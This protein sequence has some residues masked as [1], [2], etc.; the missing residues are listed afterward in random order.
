MKKI[1]N[2]KVFI[3]TIAFIGMTGVL[4]A[5]VLAFP[6]AE[7]FGANSLGG[8]GGQVIHVTT[9]NDSGPGSLREA[10]MTTGPRYVVF[11]VSGTIN[12]S[13]KIRLNASHSYLYLAG[14]TSPG[15]VQLKGTENYIMLNDGVHDVII[16]YM[17][18]RPG[19]PI[20]TAQT[21]NCLAIY[22]NTADPVT[23]IIIDHCDLMWGGDEMASNYGKTYRTT[24]QWNIIAETL[25]V[26]GIKGKGFLADNWETEA[27]Q[28]QI[29][30]SILK[31]LWVHNHDRSPKVSRSGTFDVRNNVVYNWNSNSGAKFG[32]TSLDH[33]A[34]GN[35]VNNHY[36]GGPHSTPNAFF[37]NGGSSLGSRD[38]GGTKV[39]VSGNWNDNCPTGC[40]AG[41]WTDFV[42]ITTDTGPITLASE[43]EFRTM[44]AFPVPNTTTLPTSGLKATILAGAG[45][46]LPSIDAAT[47]KV[48]DDVANSTGA[49]R[50]KDDIGGPWPD[51]ETGA[52]NPAQDTDQD[53]I[54][55]QWETD[56][57]MDANDPTD[58]PKISTNGYAYIEN[59]LNDLAGDIVPAWDN[60]GC[61][62]CNIQ[63]PFTTL[64]V[65]SQHIE[66]ED[67]DVGYPCDQNTSY[68]DDSPGNGGNSTARNDDVDLWE[69]AGIIRVGSNNPGEW[70][71]YGINLPGGMYNFTA[72]VATPN[73]GAKMGIQLGD[74][75]DGTNF[76]VVDT[77]DIP[78]TGSFTNFQNA[79]KNIVIGNGG[80]GKVM[81]LT[82]IGN[83][84]D[85]DWFEI[86]TITGVKESLP[87][88]IRIH[89]NPASTSLTISLDGYDF[90][91]GFTISMYNALGQKVLEKTQAGHQLSLDVSALPKGLYM[92]EIHVGNQI[93]TNR[94]MK[95]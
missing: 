93:L 49:K 68:Y 39:Y 88:G 10:M 12:L 78:N 1:N 36:I 48:L 30:M 37:V 14:H 92:L 71:E 72:R 75:P 13:S 64:P 32:S 85:M 81:R 84:F 20:V 21:S 7:G 69:A 63:Q 27:T 11:D 34:L 24:W 53:G 86:S 41:E 29:T 35:F 3:F 46:R 28:A 82:T 67:Y 44:T 79:S 19:G 66:A 22:G 54:P 61:V 26:E 45:A 74:G 58:A 31:N 23:D 77:I 33:S 56:N 15:G 5:Q 89:P 4:Q 51:L 52:P 90:P 70:I 9:L 25:V 38:Q 18:N 76:V 40:P 94:I 2:L 42:W 60:Q 91:Q 87:T 73:T 55:D 17:R 95:W 6:S 83:N 8:R 62:N 59:Y 16:R 80:N 47:Q 43:S 50:P 57:C 65:V